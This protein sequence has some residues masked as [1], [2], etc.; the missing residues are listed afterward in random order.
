MKKKQKISKRITTQIKL[1]LMKKKLNLCLI[2]YLEQ[3]SL[4]LYILKKINLLAKIIKK[5]F[6]KR[7]NL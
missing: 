5:K 7:F 4:K 1:D 6:A 3:F 2:I